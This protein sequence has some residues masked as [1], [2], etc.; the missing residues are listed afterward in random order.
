MQIAP[1][2]TEELLQQ[3]RMHGYSFETLKM[4]GIDVNNPA[5]AIQRARELGVPESEIDRIIRARRQRSAPAQQMLDSL[6]AGIVT[7]PDSLLSLPDSLG[8]RYDSLGVAY[9]SLGFPIDTLAI[10]SLAILD[11]L[12]AIPDT[13]DIMERIAGKGRFEGLYYYG[14]ITFLRGRETFRPVEIGPVDP[15]YLVGSGDILRLT[16]WGDVEFQYEL[17]VNR[18]GNIVIP[19]VG[20]I[21]VSGIRLADLQEKLKNYLSKYYSGLNSIK[22][23]VFMDI[24]I[25]NLRGTFVYIMGEVENPGSYKLSSYA[26]AF[27]ALYSIG[28]PKISGSLR[29]IRILREGKVVCHVDLYD[30]LLKGTST[31]DVRLQHNDIV[32]VPPRLNTIG[33]RGEVMRPGIYETTTA[34][35]ANDLVELAGGL[36]PEAY[37]FRAQIDRIKPFD[38]R[39]KGMFEREVVDV[40]LNLAAKG[41]KVFPL[42]DGD[43]VEIFE[44]RDDFDNYIDLIGKGVLRPGRYQLGNL[45]TVKDLIDAAD[46]LSDDVFIERADIIRTREDRSEVFIRIDLEA[47]MAGVPEANI[48]LERWDVIQTY[49]RSEIEEPPMVTLAG[50]VKYPGE[51][52][53]P[54]E[55]T[56]FDLMYK[57]SGL[58]DSLWR[59]RTFM[60]RG[61]VFRVESDGKTQ[62]VVSFNLDDIWNRVPGA[63]LNLLPG[64]V[65]NVYEREVTEIFEHIV[66]FD[67]E[68]KRPG[69]YE[70]KED[71]TLADLVL[72]GGGFTEKAWILEAEISRINRKGM[73]GDTLARVIRVPMAAEDS[74]V[75]DPE[76]AMPG[77]MSGQSPAADF[78]LDPYDQVYIR[79]N[80]D[81]EPP[82]SVTIK[83]EVMFPG[84]YTLR[85]RNETLH[86]LIN[87]AGGLTP[88][89]HVQGGQL[90]R[91]GSRLYVDFEQLLKSRKKSEDVILMP[92]DR[93][94]IPKKPNTVAVIGEVINPGFY[95]FV[96]GMKLKDYLRQSGGRSENGGKA[97]VILP[98]GQ[99]YISGFLKNPRVKEGSIIRVDPKPPKV[100]KER[101]EWSI[102]IKDTLAIITS[103][104]TIIVLAERL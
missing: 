45:K 74:F 49:S 11:S 91:E 55:M 73:Q 59:T 22:P 7:M 84:P 33:I 47:V 9:D 10:D 19:G 79:Q 30:Y 83:G 64:D 52:L 92:G 21:F 81:Y 88:A 86:E 36:K 38:K 2:T 93:I 50:H 13:L 41:K 37:T 43:V 80:P 98:S 94:M 103:A 35:T 68:V 1:S 95:R 102:L 6:R 46:G 32:F 26:T 15:G 34:E 70:W 8:I 71:M 82:A 48:A 99:T 56:V 65:V 78:K 58:Q 4:M 20:Q 87:R 77:I 12:A 69:Q 97:Y 39:V 25:A 57:Y 85:K 16:L 17:L 5:Q 18:D 28:G 76:D 72:E 75:D 104:V 61:T 62:R 23:T 42:A 89:A 27:N 14:Y 53:L 96:K 54:D 67:G 3:A 66:Y 44:I 60:E 40:D 100:E 29:D 90:I 24:T 31:D 51:Y 101:I 63:D